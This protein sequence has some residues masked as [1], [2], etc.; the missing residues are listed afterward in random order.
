MRK[1]GLITNAYKDVNK[2]HKFYAF[3]D[4][5]EIQ[6]ESVNFMNGRIQFIYTDLKIGEHTL[7]YVIFNKDS[8]RESNL[9]TFSI[10]NDKLEQKTQTP[11]KHLNLKI[12]P[13][14]RDSVEYI[15]DVSR[16]NNEIIVNYCLEHTCLDKFFYGMTQNDIDAKRLALCKPMILF[17]LLLKDSYDKIESYEQKNDIIIAY[18]KSIF[19][20]WNFNEK[21]R[22]K[23]FLFIFK[24]GIKSV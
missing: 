24:T 19:N 21:E 1:F 7:K 15:V 14:Q 17:A 10:E 12:N 4:G 23:P 18:L 2:A 3:L 16:T 6:P 13:M 9:Y 5:K 20:L 8:S 11:K 22:E